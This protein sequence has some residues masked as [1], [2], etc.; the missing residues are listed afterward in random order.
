MDPNATPPSGFSVS[1]PGYTIISELGKGGMATVYL[2]IQQNFGRK[3][4][5]KIMSP[6]LNA[7]P[8]FSDRFLREA[9]IV[10]GLSHP[11][12]VQVYDVGEYDNYHYIAMEYHPGGDLQERIAKGIGT[13]EALRTIKQVAL[14]LDA[15][16]AKGY[17]HRDVKP[18]NVLFREDGSAVLTDFGIAKPTSKSTRQMTQVGKVIGTPKYM[19]PEQARGLELDARSDIYALG[20]VF[21]E[22]LTGHVPFDGEDPIAIGIKHIKDPVPLLPAGLSA[23]QDVLET[24]LAKSVED[25]YQ[26][27]RDFA[28]DLDHIPLPSNATAA[29]SV[30]AE[31]RIGRSRTPATKTTPGTAQDPLWPQ[32]VPRQSRALLWSALALAGLA[33]AGTAAFFAYPHINPSRPSV[34]VAGTAIEAPRV[35][36]AAAAAAAPEAAPM[37]AAETGPDPDPTPALLELPGETAVPAMDTPAMADGALPATDGGDTLAIAEAAA[38]TAEAVEVAEAAAVEEATTARLIQGLLA[39][40]ETALGKR[41]LTRP[42]GQSALDKYREVL[43]LDAENTQASAG[44]RQ[45][46]ATYVTMARE[47]TDRRELQRADEY[48]GQARTLAPDISGLDRAETA[49]AEARAQIADEARRAKAAAEKAAAEK[50]LEATQADR[51]MAQFRI[52]GLLKSAEYQLAQG[53]LAAP[54]GDNAWDSF[55]DVLR[56]DS[57]NAMARQGQRQVIDRLLERAADAI[58][59]GDTAGAGQ[60]LDQLARIA[61]NHPRLRELRQQAEAVNP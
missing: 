23:Y 32:P 41:Q 25:R 11:H 36:P 33:L 7:D 56:L 20:V 39:E 30:R 9:R 53:K 17:I 60:W 18:D 3:V 19:S 49:L 48:L 8:T 59:S 2:A 43:L 46:A 54:P 35:N 21:F 15:A 55:Q 13:E 52:T 31:G 50:A 58:N 27:A 22:M 14:A 29:L 1:I 47:A 38:V 10:A 5:L 24:I 40:A 4:A 51:M 6:A 26:S 45:V 12:I 57:A 16:H 34:T 44:I 42:E 61:P 37:P 28:A